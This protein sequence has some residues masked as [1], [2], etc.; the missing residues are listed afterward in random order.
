MSSIVLSSVRMLKNAN[1]A[2][3]AAGITIFVVAKTNAEKR[4]PT[5]MIAKSLKDHNHNVADAL[6][7][8]G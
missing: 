4:A 7:F 5:I 6:I 2:T 8:C 1:T 3:I